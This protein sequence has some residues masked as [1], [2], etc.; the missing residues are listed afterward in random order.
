MSRS[1][2][3]FDSNPS[4]E[5]W[6]LDPNTLEGL[7]TRGGDVS[8]SKCPRPGETGGVKFRGEVADFRRPKPN[9]L[10]LGGSGGGLSSELVLP[11][12]CRVP[13]RRSCM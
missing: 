2:A 8:D 3:N 9:R 11:V 7:F 12:F 6:T 10:G 1:V 13:G 4:L 5:V